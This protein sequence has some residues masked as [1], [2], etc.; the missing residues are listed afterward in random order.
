MVL[1]YVTFEVHRCTH[2]QKSFS[3]DSPTFALYEISSVPFRNSL[4]L[5]CFVILQ[6]V[7][8]LCVFE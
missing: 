2:L 7:D 1:W 5:D 8:C 4:S 6:A 3:S